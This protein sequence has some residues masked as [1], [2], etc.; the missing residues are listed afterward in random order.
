MADT[1]TNKTTLKSYFETGDKP[2]EDQFDD[3]ITIVA[4]DKLAKEKAR[5]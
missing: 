5:D 4:L 2:T 1:L 3:L